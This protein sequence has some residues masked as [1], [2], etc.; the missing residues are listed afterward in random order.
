MWSVIG[1]PDGSFYWL[2]SF[3]G[4]YTLGTWMRRSGTTPLS[5]AELRRRVGLLRV[6]E[7]AKS[8]TAEADAAYSELFGVSFVERRSKSYGDGKASH[9]ILSL[10]RMAWV[11]APTHRTRAAASIAPRRGRVGYFAPLGPPTCAEQTLQVCVP[12]L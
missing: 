10:R 7:E 3:I 12:G 5:L 8:W 9:S 2:Q 11:C 4:E 1:Y 6:L